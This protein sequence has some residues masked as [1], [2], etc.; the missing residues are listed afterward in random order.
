[1]RHIVPVVLKQTFISAVM[2]YESEIGCL[3][4]HLFCLT[5]HYLTG[6]SIWASGV[7]MVIFHLIQ[8]SISYWWNICIL[9]NPSNCRAI[10]AAIKKI[11]SCKVHRGGNYRYYGWSI[12]W[13]L[14][15]SK[16]DEWIKLKNSLS[17]QIKG[18][19][20][21]KYFATTIE[22]RHNNLLHLHCMLSCSFNLSITK[23]IIEYDLKMKLKTLHTQ[24]H[25]ALF[26]LM[27]LTGLVSTT[28]NNNM[29]KQLKLNTFLI[30]PSSIVGSFQST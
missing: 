8:R 2:K 7:E 3:W 18:T 25:T 30:R 11:T 20:T 14:M 16:E 17:E 21:F 5:S 9:F 10:T 26:S 1:M 15:C 13:R 19:D 6:L 22:T 4:N 23:A 24:L 12:K 29:D 28:D 27:L